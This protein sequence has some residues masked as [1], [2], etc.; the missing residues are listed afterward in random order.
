MGTNVSL[1]PYLIYFR[2]I[3]RWIKFNMNF[4]CFLQLMNT[5]KPWMSPI[6][7]CTLKN[8]YSSFHITYHMQPT[9]NNNNNGTHVDNNNSHIRVFSWTSK[10]PNHFNL[11]SSCPSNHNDMYMVRFLLQWTCLLGLYIYYFLFIYLFYF[12]FNIFF[13]KQVWDINW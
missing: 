10:L 1:S 8:L 13:A 6:F 4:V 12:T 11:W 2:V 3:F 9:E 7:K 5:K